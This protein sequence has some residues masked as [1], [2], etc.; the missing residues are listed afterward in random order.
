MIRRFGEAVADLTSFI[1][2]V[3]ARE[4]EARTTRAI[5][6]GSTE[7]DPQVV[8]PDVLIDYGATLAWHRLPAVREAFRKVF[9]ASSA[10]ERR[11]L[12]QCLQRTVLPELVLQAALDEYRE[13]GNAERLLLAASIL[14]EYGEAALRPLTQMARVGAPECEYFLDALANLASDRSL[15]QSVRHALR[16]WSQHPDKAVRLGL[17]EIADAIPPAL[18]AYLLNALAD[19]SDEEVSG[20]ARELLSNAQLRVDTASGEAWQ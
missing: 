20:A 19:D 11:Q 10:A 5:E 1:E 17:V 13:R 8:A 18:K 9:A 4:G 6:P 15:F 2:R 16:D 14:E 7:T 12:A 3:R